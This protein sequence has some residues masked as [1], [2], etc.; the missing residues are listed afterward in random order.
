MLVQD[1]RTAPAAPPTASA[2]AISTGRGGPRPAPGTI[3]ALFFEA[4]RKYDKPDAMRHKVG[5]TWT[6]ISHRTVLER[7]RRV[8]LGPDATPVADGCRCA[9]EHLDEIPQP[10]HRSAVRE[11]PRGGPDDQPLQILGQ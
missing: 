6:P 11:G 2:Q 9:R 1:Q 3:N 8:A 5:G 4:A 10:T 7:V